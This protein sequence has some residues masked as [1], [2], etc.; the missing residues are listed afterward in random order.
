MYT[1]IRQL[2]LHLQSAFVK[3]G[4]LCFSQQWKAYLRENYIIYKYLTYCDCPHLN[5][6]GCSELTN[7]S[8]SSFVL[9][10]FDLLN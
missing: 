3:K 5:N 4:L 10:H 2:V 1:M 7:S 8:V 9:H 6:G